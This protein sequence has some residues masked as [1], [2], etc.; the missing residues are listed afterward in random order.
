MFSF[1]N[2]G[3]SFFKRLLSPT[4]RVLDNESWIKFP[5]L[6]L[7]LGQSRAPLFRGRG[8]FLHAC[9]NFR[10][11][12][13]QPFVYRYPATPLHLPHTTAA[14]I[15][16]FLPS[17][18]LLPL[19]LPLPLRCCD[20]HCHRCRVAI[21]PSIAVA[22]A[23]SIAAVAVA[24]A[25][26]PSIAVSAVAIACCIAVVSSLR[27]RPAFHCHSQRVAVAIASPSNFSSPLPL[28]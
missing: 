20:I 13:S 11:C 26:A 19:H 12:V 1:T 6:H 21:V 18:L 7:S 4:Q 22:V 9:L 5:S 8:L 10:T 3:I 17:L 25:V 28:R 15:K 2:P 14:S 27:C 24:V 23:P 16:S